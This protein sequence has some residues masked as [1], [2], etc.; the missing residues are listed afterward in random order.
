MIAV[1]GAATLLFASGWSHAQAYPSRPVRIVVPYAAGQGTDV[2]TRYLADQPTKVL[3]QSVI[4]D[5]R[6]GAAGNVGTLHAAKA[7]AD[8][9]TILMGTNGTHAAAPFL[10]A[11]LGF[12]PQADFEPIVLTVVTSLA[13]VTNAG[14]PVDD[15]PKLVAAAR[16]RPDTINVAYKTTSSRAVLELFK[17]QAGAPLFGVPYKGSAQAIGDLLGGQVEFMVDTVASLR[18]QI[19]AGKLNALAI[20]SRS[21]S[22]VLPGVK[23]VAEQGVRDFEITGWN[24]LYAPKNTPPEAIRTLAS[25]TTKVLAQPETRQ[26][27]L[28]LGMEV[29][30]MTGPELVSSSAPSA[31]SGDRS[32]VRPGSR[33]TDRGIRPA[34]STRP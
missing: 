5:N 3:G 11:D 27:L 7:P 32:S 25:A 10:F 4:V 18:A 2:L 6:P 19:A 1:F 13:I 9:Y 12:D 20:T 31:R 23:S 24:V 29:R 8:G 21:S 22:D 33:R 15:V 17:Q 34:R 26:Y 14:N 16:A 30:P 28:N